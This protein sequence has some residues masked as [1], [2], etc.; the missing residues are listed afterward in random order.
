MKEFEIAGDIGG[1]NEEELIALLVNNGFN[2]K[3]K[4]FNG[5]IWFVK[6]NFELTLVLDSQNNFLFR[7][8]L[9]IEEEY[10]VENQALYLKNIF[11]TNSLSFIIEAYNNSDSFRLIKTYRNWTI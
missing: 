10:Q 6:D 2:F 1:I 8:Y 3:K 4:F 7:Y 9:E 5:Y 11:E